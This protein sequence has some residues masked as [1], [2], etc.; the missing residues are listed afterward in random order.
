MTA[1]DFLDRHLDDQRRGDG[2]WL[3]IS[4]LADAFRGSSPSQR[5]WMISDPPR[6]DAPW[7]ALLAGVV[8]DLCEE[9][10]MT[11]PLWT[12]GVIAQEP[13]WIWPNITEEVKGV[14]RELTKPAYAKHNVFVPGNF[15]SRA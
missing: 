12:I 1:A 8:E 3:A 14:L 9:V 15:L 2:A 11:P 10:G 5:L 6:A 13:F 4:E 7:D